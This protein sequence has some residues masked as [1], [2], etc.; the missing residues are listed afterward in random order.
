MWG[1][2]SPIAAE[3][4]RADEPQRLKDALRRAR[5]DTA[6][7]SGVVVDL[8][9]AEVARLELLNEALD[10][11]F[12]KSRRRSTCSTAGFRVATRRACGSTPSP[13][14][15]WDATSASTVSCRTLATAARC[16]GRVSTSPRCRG[17][18]KI[19][20]A[21]VDRARTR[22][23]RTCCA[24]NRRHSPRGA[25]RTQASP[26]PRHPGVHLWCSR[27]LCR[28]DRARAD[29]AAAL[30]SR[31]SVAFD[32]KFLKLAAWSAEPS[33]GGTSVCRPISITVSSAIARHRL[34]APG[35]GLAI[36]RIEVV[37]GGIVLLA[38]GGRSRRHAD[39][40][41]RVAGSVEP[42][43]EC[44]RDR[45]RAARSSAPCG[46]AASRKARRVDQPL[47]HRLR[48]LL[49]GG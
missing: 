17:G 46:Q 31:A 33:I 6:E 8:H 1:R 29:P 40:G 43:T 36:D 20:R 26:P 12:S 21:A 37:G 14:W 34:A 28:A 39:R 5:I 25:V 7:R 45:A 32:L 19:C 4:A 38:R 15:P 44:R 18:D 2:R 11:L 23:R 16:S 30:I 24:C 47:E 41:D 3:E 27:R 22:A 9:D 48:R 35:A 42:D 49:I 13:T 10:P